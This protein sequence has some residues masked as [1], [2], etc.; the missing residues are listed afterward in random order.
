MDSNQFCDAA[1]GA[2]DESKFH[3]HMRLGSEAG[4]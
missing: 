1:K 2:I 3:V 4:D